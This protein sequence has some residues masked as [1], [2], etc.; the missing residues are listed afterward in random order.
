MKTSYLILAVSLAGFGACRMDSVTGTVTASVS[1]KN[2]T[3]IERGFAGYNVALSGAAIGY[4]NERLLALASTLAPGWLRYPAGT[5]SDA[6]D[7][8]TG[9][10]PQAWVDRFHVRGDT[11]PN[12][13]YYFPFLEKIHMVLAGKGGDKLDDAVR[14]ANGT[15]AVGLIVCVN[16]FTDTPASAGAFAAYARSHGIRVL[17]WQLANEAYLP[18]FRGFFPTASDYARQMQPFADAIK[19]A[20][21]SAKISLFLSNASFPDTTWDQGLAAFRPRYWDLLSYHQYPLFSEDSLADLLA[22]LDAE[23]VLNS[24]GYVESHVVPRFGPMPVI[25]TEADPG[26]GQ[27]PNMNGTLYGGVWA[28]EY[29]MRLSRLPQV[30]HVGMHQLSGTGGVDMAHDHV[31]DVVNAYKRGVT[32]DTRT[33]DFGLFISAQGAAYALAAR[34]IN[35]ASLIYPTVTSGGA[36]IRLTPVGSPTRG[37][38]QSATG[39]APAGTPLAK[40]GDTA[41]AVFAQAYGEQSGPVTVVVTNKGVHQESLVIQ[42]DGLRLRGPFRVTTVTGSGPMVVNSSAS[43]AVKEVSSEARDAVVLPPYS[44]VRITW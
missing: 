14:F 5:K 36:T 23:L 2:P 30:K 27:P 34:T 35:S 19:K 8:H 32:L 20:D 31:D 3:A 39:F 15:G 18:G 38:I 4:T 33:L 10:S 25:V 40:E 44:V 24:A 7:W 22:E 6:F 37:M 26:M 41:P 28:A 13:T 21:P 11:D 29:A 17:A 1:T 9:L 12:R 42:V 16:A 43:A